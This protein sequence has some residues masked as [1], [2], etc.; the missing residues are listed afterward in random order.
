MNKSHR[1]FAEY[2]RPDT[3]GY[4]LYNS[5]YVYEFL[6]HSEQLFAAVLK[7]DCMIE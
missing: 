3:K 2:T 6:K 1:E 5:T 7:L 4:I